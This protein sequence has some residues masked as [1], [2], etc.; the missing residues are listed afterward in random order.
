MPRTSATTA[1]AHDFPHGTVDG[2]GGRPRP[3]GVGG[4]GAPVL[5]APDGRRLG[6]VGAA[7]RQSP[8]GHPAVVIHDTHGD[9][10]PVNSWT[11]DTPEIPLR[12]ITTA[13]PCQLVD[14]EYTAEGIIVPCEK[15]RN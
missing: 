2:G 12:L 10:S 7:R 5:P 4:P 3:G 14:T 1:A 9:T 11:L 13:E 8:D 6:G 15:V